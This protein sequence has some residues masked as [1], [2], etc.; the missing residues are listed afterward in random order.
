[1]MR[2][3]KPIELEA[4]K[5]FGLPEARGGISFCTF[6]EAERG[7]S[8]DRKKIL[9]TR[10]MLAIHVLATSMELAARLFATQNELHTMRRFI[11]TSMPSPPLSIKLLS[12]V[13]T[14]WCISQ[15]MVPVIPYPTNRDIRS[16]CPADRDTIDTAGKPVLDISDQELNV[17]LSE[18]RRAKGDRITVFLD[19]SCRKDVL[20]ISLSDSR[21]S[22][23]LPPSTTPAHKILKVSEKRLSKMFPDHP[24]ILAQDWRPDLTSHDIVTA[25]NNAQLAWEVLWA[26]GTISGAFTQRLL[27]TLREAAKATA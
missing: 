14:L 10:E 27:E 18:I 24:S 3:L 23:S 5:K 7:F 1:M 11:L 15:G 16:V 13:I 19:C 25:C 20:G 8:R 2:R 4:A 9:E 26:D 21:K 22:R 12:L 6:A 17:I